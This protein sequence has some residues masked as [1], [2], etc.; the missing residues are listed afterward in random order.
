[1]KK[2]ALLL[3]AT[4]LYG[5]LCWRPLQHPK[6]IPEDNFI[7]IAVTYTGPDSELK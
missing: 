5:F 1:M 6:P 3:L 7:L 2:I 4:L